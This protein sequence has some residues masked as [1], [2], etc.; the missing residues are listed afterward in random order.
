[1]NLQA[2]GL[3]GERHIQRA[4][5][6]LPIPKFDPN[7]PKHRRL[8][9]LSKICHEVVKK[10]KVKSRKKVKEKLAKYM[11]EVDA[12]VEEILSEHSS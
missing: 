10:F 2:K 5:F 7:D 8:A 6:E 11:K 4:I 9:E 1:M 3:W 12:L